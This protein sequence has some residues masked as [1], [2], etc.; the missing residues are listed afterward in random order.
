[1]KRR[2][3]FISLLL[4]AVSATVH[5]ADKAHAGRESLFSLGAGTSALGMGG[6]YTSFGRDASTVFYNPAGLPWMEYQE[7]SAM[8]VTF[9][10]GTLYDVACWGVP[11]VGVGGFGAAFMRVGTDDIIRRT[12]FVNEGTFDFTTWQFLLGYGRKF[13][14]NVSFGAT[15]K[16]VNQS[17]DAE[18][19]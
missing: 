3:L 17:L 19:D 10:Q 8:H 15:L 18:S 7:I 14:S 1:M 5:A 9:F 6:A 12:N 13:G 2:C 11:V 4:V 16:I